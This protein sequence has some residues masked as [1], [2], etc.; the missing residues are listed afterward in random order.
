MDTDDIVFLSIGKIKSKV[1][2]GSTNYI[3]I[4]PS[5]HCIILTH[6]FGLKNPM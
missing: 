5:I 1:E 2:D 3:L 4:S 6:Q